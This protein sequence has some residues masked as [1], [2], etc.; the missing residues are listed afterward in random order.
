[1]SSMKYLR[2]VMARN[3]FIRPLIR[4]WPILVV[5]LILAVI[6]GTEMVATIKPGL[7]PHVKPR[8]PPTYTATEV[9][10]VNSSANPLVR[11]A[12]TAVVPKPAKITLLKNHSGSS[13][14]VT[15]VPQAPSVSVHSPDIGVLVRA[16]N[17]YPRLIESDEVT[18]L[19]TK[20]F[21][22]QHG[23]VVAAALNSFQ[24]PTKYRPSS[25]PMIQLAATA[26]HPNAA[27]KL[28]E[29]T[30]A[31]FEKWLQDN[32]AQAGVPAAE[33][34]LVTDL[35]RPTSAV[36]SGGT[37]MGLPIFA[38]FIVFLV[39]AGIAIALDRLQMAA[40]AAAA[41]N[42]PADV[43][44]ALAAGVAGHREQ[45]EAG[46]VELPAAQPAGH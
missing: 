7:P 32:Q 19:R 4:F 22:P 44:T 12:V 33:R 29:N 16:A 36:S 39:F 13:N 45:R 40:A 2:G 37:K 15:S 20:M 24:T 10:L 42:R 11:T 26:K 30:A 27:I 3:A 5:G 23:H 43:E 18:A 9:L 28:A 8:T 14:G 31:A 25:F 35:V 6:M 46:D 41:A 1:M 38:G 34:I 21:G 17:L